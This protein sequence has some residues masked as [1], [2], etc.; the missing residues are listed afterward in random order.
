MVRRSFE[1]KAIFNTTN[2]CAKRQV[3][4]STTHIGAIA[5]VDDVGISSAAPHYFPPYQSGE[6]VRVYQ[7]DIQND[8]SDWMSGKSD[9]G[10]QIWPSDR[11]TKTLSEVRLCRR[12]KYDTLRH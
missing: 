2:T 5:L 6:P 8:I 4:S 7:S 12:T 3:H 1:G 10:T 9:L 11:L